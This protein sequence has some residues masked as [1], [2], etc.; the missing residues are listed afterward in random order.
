MP[1]GT[2]YDLKK[3]QELL[4]SAGLDPSVLKQLIP[5]SEASLEEPKTR[6]PI[7]PVKPKYT[8]NGETWRGRGRTPLKIV[9]AIEELGIS[10]QEFKADL[11]YRI[12]QEDV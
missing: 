8:I 5:S 12:N 10:V 11:Q 3:V 2:A 4:G 1:G 7:G 6:K 9:S